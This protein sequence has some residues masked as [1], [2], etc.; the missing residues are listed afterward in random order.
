MTPVRLLCTDLDGVLL[1]S[2]GGLSRDTAKALAAARAA[3]LQVMVATGRPTR[4]A[5][6]WAR[7]A[8]LRGLLACSNGAV[9]W[10]TCAGR[11]LFDHCFTAGQL[12]RV[13]AWA[14]RSVPGGVLGLDTE[15]EL[16]LQPGFADLVPGCWP[17]TASADLLGR[18]SRGN[19]AVKVLLAHP[20]LSAPQLAGAFAGE[21]VTGLRATFSTAHFLEISPEH[22]NKGEALRWAAA[23]RRIPLAATAAVGDMPNDL[24]MLRRAGLPAAVANAHPEVKAAA[25]ILLPSND[26]DGV[27]S[28]IRALL[29]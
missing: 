22:A 20:E 24:P 16:V 2:A 1:T 8:G 27:A 12:K 10:D 23:H 14:E 15:H 17:H 6:E 19:R 9:I 28:L 21:A 13:V 18:A 25:R 29:R 11:V 26:D 4:D 3:G 7:E 5:L